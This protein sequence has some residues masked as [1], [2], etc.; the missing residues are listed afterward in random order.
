[1]I[2]GL[3]R[4]TI[5]LAFHDPEWE[6]SAAQTIQQLW[7]I[8]GSMAKDIQHI[9]S[10]AIT[11]IKAKPVI[12]IAVAVKNFDEVVDL[13]PNLEEKGFIFRGFEGKDRQPVYQCGEFIS[14]EDDMSFLTHYI[15]VVEADSRQWNSY[16]NFRD[17][18]NSYPVA[19]SEYETLK[20]RLLDENMDDGNLRK[21]HMG[22]QNYVAEM[23]Q[24]ANLWNDMGRSITI[25]C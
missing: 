15:H 24:V 13:S 16:I 11:G 10:T 9:G 8:F 7:E 23:I 17:Y 18:M 21:Y 5:T 3:K 4:G 6:K 22:K 12:D 1:M 25:N 14:G 2:L 19:A 20:L